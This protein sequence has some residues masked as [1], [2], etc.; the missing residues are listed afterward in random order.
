MI[1]TVWLRS[2]CT[3]IE[4]GHFTRTA[5][6]LHITQSGVSQ[7][8]RKL[9]EQLG[10][11][12]IDRQGKK[13]MPTDAGKR[14]YSEARGII[15]ALSSLENRITDDPPF[16][17]LVRV[18]SP[19]SVGLKL[20]PQLLGLQQ[21]H[22]QLV[23]DYRFA[24]NSDIENAILKHDIDI[25]FMT[26]AAINDEVSCQPVGMETLLLVTPPA[27][28]K[29]SWEALSKLGFID[30]PDGSHH[31]DL[32]LGANFNEYEGS[33]LLSKKGFSNQIN[34]ILEPVSMGL[35]FTVLP[36]RA[37]EAFQKS[38]LV[39]VHQL[40]TPVSEILY[41]GVRRH[42]PIQGRVSTVINAAKDLL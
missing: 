35:G 5:E 40:P 7:H 37:V 17:G 42:T 24:P 34:L 33:N 30:H 14:L 15:F 38:R 16:E 23:I 3:L 39:K 21:K 8:V 22:P 20:Y 25:G 10:V 9:E 1:N 6:R 36:A 19:G 13:F 18:M 2:F 12:L 27:I 11:A 4:M 28:A 31:A 41:L 29:P 26:R 32:L